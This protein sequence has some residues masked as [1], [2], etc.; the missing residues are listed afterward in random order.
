MSNDLLNTELLEAEI[1][2]SFFETLPCRRS[3]RNTG[4]KL[5]YTTLASQ[6]AENDTRTTSDRTGT[7]HDH[8][9]DGIRKAS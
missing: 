1:L 4:A 7:I 8:V 5:I 9:G 2:G 3:R 6:S